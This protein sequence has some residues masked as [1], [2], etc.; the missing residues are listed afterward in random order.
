MTLFYI[1]SMILAAVLLTASMY[2]ERRR[3][4]QFKV[5]VGDMLFFIGIC[6]IPIVNMLAAFAAL[7]WIINQVKDTVVVG[8]EQ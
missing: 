7:G 8:P 6:I 5:T 2:L 3:D 4:K 1:V